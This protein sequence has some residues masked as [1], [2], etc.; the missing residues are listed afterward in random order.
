MYPVGGA[1]KCRGSNEAGNVTKVLESG[2]LRVKGASVGLGGREERAR[3]KRAGG[4]RATE[5][6]IESTIG[7]RGSEGRERKESESRKR[8]ESESSKRRREEREGE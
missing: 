2:E 3:G 6:K 8:E 4:S 1:T 7:K 5:D